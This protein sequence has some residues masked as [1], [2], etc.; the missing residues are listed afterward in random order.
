MRDYGKLYT[1]FWT[2]SNTQSMSDDAKLMA[3]Y[4]LTGPHTNL[5]GCFRVPEGY[6]ISDLGWTSQRVSKGF[7]ELFQ[8]GFATRDEPL[9]WVFIQKF[10]KWNQ[11]ENPNQAKSAAKLFHQVPD[12]T[13]IKCLLARAFNE[14]APRID[15]KIYEHF[16]NCFETLSEPFRNQEQKQEQKIYIPSNFVELSRAYHE[17]YSKRFP[18]LLKRVPQKL[19]DSGAQTIQRLVDKEK[20]DFE[21]D[22]KPALRFALEDDFW[23]KQIRSLAGL[24]KKSSSNGDT[25][26]AN[27]LAASMKKSKPARKQTIEDYL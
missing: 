20:Y 10:L 3:A 17:E 27:L 23:Q 25:K 7:S 22:I 8:K 5:I 18:K 13:P 14:F 24:L 4:L 19:I 11:I 2:S 21:N 6:V 1:G 15:R 12:T 26:F 16:L 9:S